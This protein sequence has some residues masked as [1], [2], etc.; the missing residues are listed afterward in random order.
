MEAWRKHCLLCPSKRGEAVTKSSFH[1]SIIGN[2]MVYQDRLEANLCRYSGTQ[3]IQNDFLL[4]P[5]IIFEVNNV[6]EQKQI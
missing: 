4:F 2:F 3:K 6:D 1:K 5:V